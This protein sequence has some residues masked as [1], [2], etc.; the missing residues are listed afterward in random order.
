M[1][2]YQVEIEEHVPDN[3]IYKMPKKDRKYLID[4]GDGYHLRCFDFG[5]FIN[6]GSAQLISELLNTFW[7]RIS[8]F[9]YQ[10]NVL[11]VEELVQHVLYTPHKR[12]N[13]AK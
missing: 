6:Y 1:R 11:E 12:E 7:N 13:D 9:E 4:T 10:V 5:R 2:K 3:M 8:D